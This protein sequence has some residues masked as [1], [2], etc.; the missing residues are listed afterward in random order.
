MK[1]D[2]VEQLI[3]AT[4][5]LGHIHKMS[6]VHG[7]LKGLNV[8]IDDAGAAKLCDFG[9]SIIDCSCSSM[10]SGTEGSIW[11]DSPELWEDEEGNRTRESD[12][13]ALGCL[14]IE[15]QTGRL[16][17]G[18]A[19]P[20]VVSWRQASGNLPAS[21]DWFSSHP[22]SLRDGLWSTL[23]SCWQNDPTDRPD[24]GTVLAQLTALLPA[25]EIMN[26]E[27]VQVAD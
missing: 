12:I 19:N 9:S 7:D 6:I 15:I 21:Q 24:V 22:A 10:K 14:S 17:Y 13:W 25:N 3:D 23:N 2:L 16:P 1:I 8:I 11:W 5:G 18:T 27:I 4:K 26:T 20:N